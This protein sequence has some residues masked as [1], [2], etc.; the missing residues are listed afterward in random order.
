[1]GNAWDGSAEIKQYYRRQLFSSGF[2]VS[3][4][5]F[6]FLLGAGEIGVASSGVRDT[7]S[8]ACVNLDGVV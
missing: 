5:L 3:A 6:R 1:M 2:V 4:G 8:R 7:Y